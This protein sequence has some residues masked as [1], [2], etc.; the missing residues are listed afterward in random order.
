MKI[1]TLLYPNGIDN[2]F[3][4]IEINNKIDLEKKIKEILYV[5]NIGQGQ[6]L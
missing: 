3:L 6:D 2:N 1:K 5:G 4:D